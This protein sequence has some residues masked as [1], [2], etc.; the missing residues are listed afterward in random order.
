M[1]VCVCVCVCVC[2]FCVIL[3]ALHY[4]CAVPPINA[5]VLRWTCDCPTQRR[6]GWEKER[7]D[8]LAFAQRTPHLYGECKPRSW[9]DPANINW[10]LMRLMR[11][12]RG[13]I[14]KGSSAVL[15]LHAV[16]TDVTCMG[17]ELREGIFHVTKIGDIE[18]PRTKTEVPCLIRAAGTL[19]LMKVSFDSLELW[20]LCLFV[21]PSSVH[22][23]FMTPIQDFIRPVTGQRLEKLD[24]EDIRILRGTL[25][26]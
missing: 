6:L 21:D 4:C 13:S 12:G 11:F 7:P 25:Q 20:C 9:G 14:V 15:L 16:H 2:C 24:I 18:V 17:M 19:L 8:F 1:C 26:P 5:A 23:I 3:A 22:L 10:D